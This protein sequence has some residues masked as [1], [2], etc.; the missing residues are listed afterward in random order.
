MMTKNKTSRHYKLLYLLFVPLVFGLLAAFSNIPVRNN[1]MTL[2]TST[3]PNELVIL[4]D[5]GHGGGDAGS[6]SQQ[7]NEKDLALAIAKEIQLTGGEKGL[8]VILTRTSDQAIS[9]DDRL[10][11]VKKFK[12]DMFLSIHLNYDGGNASN[13]GIDIMVSERNAQFEKSSRIAEQIKNELNSLGS[14]KVNGILNSNFYVLSRNAVPAALL[15]L[16]YLSNSSDRDYVA[17]PKNQKAIS[18]KI[19][20]AVLA[21]VK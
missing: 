16:G 2:L 10:S 3:D 21:S 7:A 6:H 1:D 9:L 12:A 8:K 19:V 17:D 14:L 11:M 4:I 18:E 5:P 15:E 20:N 13:S